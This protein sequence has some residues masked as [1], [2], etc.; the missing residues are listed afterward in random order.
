[1]AP[2]D[3]LIAFAL[4]TAVFAYIPGPAMLYAAAQTL[5]RGQRGGFKATLGIHVGGYAHV[6]AAALGLSAIFTHVPEAYAALKFIGAAYLIF[7]GIQMIRHRNDPLDIPVLAQK[8]ER[9]AFIES[10]SVEVLNPKTAIFY[11][12][13]LPQFADPAAALP[14]WMQLLILGT[15]VNLAFSSADVIAVMLTARL[16]HAAKTSMARVR[17]AR[18]AAGS[19]LMGLGA[20]LA[21]DRS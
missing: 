13:F 9:R 19:V 10:V 15:L 5:A 7:L 8:S 11:I 20:R 18:V 12:A 4:A 1:M 21:L 14:V 2:L 17:V 6:L 3:V 16:S